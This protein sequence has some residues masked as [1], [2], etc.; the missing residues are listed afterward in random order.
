MVF[1]NFD[2][3]IQFFIESKKT[4][5]LINTV[6]QNLDLNYDKNLVCTQ[7]SKVIHIRSFYSELKIYVEQKEFLRCSEID[8]ETI[9]SATIDIITDLNHCFVGEWAFFHSFVVTKNN[10]AILLVGPTHQGKTTLGTALT[11]EGYGYLSDDVAII[12]DAGE[13]Y[14]L[15]LP[16]KLR[17]NTILNL[18]T[19]KQKYNVLETKNYFFLT[20]YFSNQNINNYRPKKVVFLNRKNS[21]T[22]VKIKQIEDYEAIKKLILNAAICDNIIRHSKISKNLVQ[23][24][25]EI[26]NVDYWSGNDILDTLTLRG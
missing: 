19:I 23:L 1:I 26:I 6:F 18:E 20:P 15:S 25:D 13:L 7:N 21:A 5:K 2:C 16:I 4:F 3:S 9:I 8:N 22:R 12:N 11:L 17:K 24:C 10:E 14:G